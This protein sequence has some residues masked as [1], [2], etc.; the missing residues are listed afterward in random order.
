MFQHTNPIWRSVRDGSVR[1]KM[2]ELSV[3]P[4]SFTVPWYGVRR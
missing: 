4:L 2:P 3:V 1:R